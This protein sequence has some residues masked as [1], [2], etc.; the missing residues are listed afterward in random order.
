ML[1]LR[2]PQCGVSSS[3]NH[4]Y[5]YAA[6]EEPAAFGAN[7]SELVT[8]S[9]EVSEW[10]NDPYITNIVPNWTSPLGKQYGCTSVLEVGDP[11]AGHAFTVTNNGATRHYQDETFFSWFTRAKPSIGINGKYTY[12]NTFTSYSA[13]C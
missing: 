1:R 4:A 11:V 2:L 7:W 8:H 3:G 9:H 10:F 13:S 5:A 12:L 6:W